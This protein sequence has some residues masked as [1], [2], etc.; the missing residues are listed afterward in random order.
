MTS[1]PIPNP[2][3]SGKYSKQAHADLPEQA[4][5]EREIGREGFFGAASHLHHKHP[6][7]G[8]KSWSGE[9][10]PRAYDLNKIQTDYINPW[11]TNILF[12]SEYC[13]V[14]Y[15]RCT[16]T[17]QSLVRNADGD[18]LL[19]IHAGEGDLYCDYGHLEINT[20]D[21][22]LIPRGTMWR[23]NPKSPF[24]ILMVE[25]TDQIFQLPNKG[26]L[27][28]HAIF[29]PAVIETPEINE[30]FLNQQN[31]DDWDIIVKKHNTLNTITYPFNPLDAIGWHG[32]LSVIKIN[33]RDIRPITSH[34]LH[35][36]PS[37]H[38]TF[39]CPQIMVSTFV[40]RPIESDPGALKVPFYHSNDDYDEFI[41]YHYGEFISRDNIKP[42][43]VSFHPSGFT[44]GPH[45]KAFKTGQSAKRKAT[46]EVAV[47]LDLRKALQ[48]TKDAIKVEDPDYINCWR[49]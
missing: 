6:P 12:E 25:A 42:G 39:I 14:R 34:R 38:C 13:Q 9:L 48:P 46:D 37:A 8:W 40:P 29:D 26:I 33:W 22:V 21:Y 31:E 49:E 28:E 27:G 30:N 5:Y 24:E 19:F 45:P 35:L 36:P 32:N 4:I 3:K 17:M 43:M 16:N 20:G 1:K 23:I 47:M 44:H 15:W 41:F 10:R 18:Q 2:R 7:T 11:E